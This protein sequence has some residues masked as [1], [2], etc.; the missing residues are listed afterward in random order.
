ML[1]MWQ[2]QSSV[3]KKSNQDGEKRTADIKTSN[4]PS[5]SIST[6]PHASNLSTSTVPASAKPSTKPKPSSKPTAKPDNQTDGTKVE[7][8]YKKFP[9][10]EIILGS[11]DPAKKYKL[12]VQL[13]N[14]AAAIKTTKLTDY[15]FTV[16]D[17]KLCKKLKN[18]KEYLEQ[19]KKNPKLK[20]HY[21]LLNPV[22]F[23]GGKIH[24]FATR[25]ITFYID[26]REVHI[27]LSGPFWRLTNVKKDKDGTNTAATFTCTIYRNSKPFVKLLKTYTIRPKTSNPA[28]RCY[29]IDVKLEVINLS[30]QKVK[31]SLWQFAAT[32]VPREDIQSDNRMI[33]YGHIEGGEGFK[34]ET[35]SLKD[36]GKMELLTASLENLRY[37]GKSDSS[38]AGLWIG[39]INKF[40]AAL[41]YIIPQDASSL[42][43]P[44]ARANFFTAALQETPTSRTFLSGMTF[45]PFEINASQNKSI[46]IDFFVGPK[47]RKLFNTTPLYAKLHYKKTLRFGS[48]CTFAPLTLGMMWLMDLFSKITFGNYGMAI[49]LLVVLVR[50]ALH[51]LTRKGQVSMSRMQKLAPEMAKIR[52]K[53]AD[54]KAKMNEEMMKLYK[55]QGFT[56]LLGCLPMLL[57]MPIWIALWTGLRAAVELRH[58]PFLPVWITNLAGP[59]ALISWDKPLFGMSFPMVGPIVSFNLLPILLAIGMALQQKFTPSAQAAD[60]KQAKS[61][62]QMMYFMTGFFLLIFYNAP[63]GLTLYIMTSTFAG[64]VEQYVI[65]KHIQEKEA[66]QA[67]TETTVKMP[68][69][70]FRGQKPKKPQG[71]FRVKW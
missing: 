34:V 49:I 1:L 59:D 9:I 58:A 44:L 50:I 67:A 31:F 5:P 17:K 27:D 18:H 64:L 68:G 20:G 71:P 38:D 46:H 30:K 37:L 22:N 43:A 32:G 7:W 48:C 21:S 36:L 63:S 70:Y 60:P 3:E 10:R 29:S 24:P 11:N 40:F 25:R 12:Q 65:R 8:A 47:K 42:S 53:Y 39:Q 54:D 56:P 51:P 69:K 52:E 14:I 23:D 19:V 16:K 57:Q 13:T 55:A 41:A 28:N 4:S 2:I 61:Q 33:A 6:R 45:G 26:S 35:L 62:K 15:F 66:A